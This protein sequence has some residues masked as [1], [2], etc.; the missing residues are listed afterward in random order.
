MLG[1]YVGNILRIDLASKK[2]SKSKLD[3]KLALD[4]ISGRGIGD[5][6]LY[7]NLAIGADPLSP[8]NVIILT[9]GLLTGTN[10]PFSSRSWIVTKS[11]LSGTILMSNS[12]GYLGP[13]LKFAGYDTLILTGKAGVPSYL[14]INDDAIEIRS[15]QKLWGLGIKETQRIIGEETDNRAIVACIG[16]AAEKLVRFACIRVGDRAFGR[17]GPG[18]VLASKN[19]KAIAVRGHGTVNVADEDAFNKIVAQILD[20]YKNHAFIQEWRKFGTPYIVGP[21]NELGIFPTRN[22]Q[23]GLFDAYDKIDANAHRHHVTKH[24]TCFKCPVACNSW[25]VVQNGEYAGSECRGPEYETI[26]AF[27]GQCGNS[28]LEAIIAANALC[29]ELGMDTESTGNAIGFAMELYERGIITDAD[30]GGIKLTF[31]NHKAMFQLVRMIGNREGIGDVLAE[32]VKKASEKIGK[33]AEKLAM[34]VKGLE[35]DGYDPRGAKAQGLAYATASRGGCHHSGYAKQELYDATFD[36]FTGKGKGKITRQNEDETALVDSTGLCAFPHQLGV[37]SNDQIAS[38]LYAT[39]GIKE[40]SDVTYL[41]RA[42]ERIMNLER[43]FNLREGF[44]NK[45]DVLPQ[46][47]QK[48]PMPTGNSKGQVVDFEP[49]LKEYY[50]V[51]GWSKRGIPKKSKLRELGLL[52]LA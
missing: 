9:T 50:A 21:M 1:G 40:F 11:P 2:V 52:K 18:A 10:A 30:T 7:D 25:S 20:T 43:L 17:G 31:G 24:V 51:R 36:R 27:G 29:N 8:E 22:F 28:N 15:A 38:L 46:R 47:F 45:D 5:K 32:G 23:T 42:G 13:E 48:E 6:F 37:L 26:W 4:F 39:S 49:M 33:G 19:L 14:W 3:E 41:L 16:P 44:T 35:I 34:H 12:G